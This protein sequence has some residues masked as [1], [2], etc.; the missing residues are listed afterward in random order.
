MEEPDTV[1]TV[2]TLFAPG[3]RLPTYNWEVSYSLTNTLTRVLDGNSS[4]TGYHCSRLVKVAKH[5]RFLQRSSTIGRV[6]TSGEGYPSNRLQLCR[7]VFIAFRLNLNIHHLSV[8]VKSSILFRTTRL[9]N[10]QFQVEPNFLLVCTLSLVLIHLMVSANWLCYSS[11]TLTSWYSIMCI[12]YC[13]ASQT[14][15]SCCSAIRI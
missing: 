8:E 12:Q 13:S 4:Q 14:P 3:S 7:S 15:R 2:K 5:H 1:L 9:T 6:T 11:Q 10:Y